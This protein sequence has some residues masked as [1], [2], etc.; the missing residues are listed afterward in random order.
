MNKALLL[1]GGSGEVTNWLE[2][3]I[4]TNSIPNYHLRSC[5][6]HNLDGCTEQPWEN[7]RLKNKL[8]PAY[9]GFD[10]KAEL[11][12]SCCGRVETNPISSIH[13]DAD[14]I[15]GPAQWVGDL[16]LP[17]AVLVGCRC[18]SDPKLLWLWCRP[19]AIADL[20]PSLG[21]S[22]CCKCGPK[23]KKKKYPPPWV[24]DIKINK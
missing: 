9:R 16:A 5:T 20:T 23:K 2:W 4:N 22:L 8:E 11:G 17:C 10:Y 12:S 19:S 18:G 21:T 6:T 1:Y 14:S 24:Q 15:P 13:E 3:R 7:I